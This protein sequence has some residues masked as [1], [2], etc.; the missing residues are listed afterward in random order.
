[1]VP[2]I[3][4]PISQSC[5][6]KHHESTQCFGTWWWCCSILPPQIT[7]QPH[8]FYAFFKVMSDFFFLNFTH[9]RNC[10]STLVK[11]L[12]GEELLSYL[13]QECLIRTRSLCRN[14]QHWKHNACTI[15]YLI[16]FLNI[17]DICRC[18]SGHKRKCLLILCNKNPSISSY[19]ERKIHSFYNKGEK[20]NL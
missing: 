15:K 13:Q 16:I 14:I 1:M 17:C 6:L 19:R 8:T 12:Q 10:L 5:H 4:K 18:L 2:I 20:E 7:S 3:L 9:D 11:C